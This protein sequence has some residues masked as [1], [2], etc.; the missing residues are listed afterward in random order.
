MNHPQ[1]PTPTCDCGKPMKREME[2]DMGMC[3]DCDKF[4]SNLKAP[5]PFDLVSVV[6]SF[7][8]RGA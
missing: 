3:V 7:F 5:E 1:E 2:R 8:K 4:Y 6:N